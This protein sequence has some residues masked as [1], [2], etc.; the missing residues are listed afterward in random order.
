M[1][2]P[3]GGDGPRERHSGGIWR[4][5]HP[6]VNLMRRMVRSQC[7]GYEH[8]SFSW[9]IHTKS[10]ATRSFILNGGDGLGL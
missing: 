9:R 10:Y 2:F 1:A 8:D 4:W 7:S 5:T 6:N 3:A